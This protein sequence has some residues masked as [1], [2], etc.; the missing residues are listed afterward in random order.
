[1]RPDLPTGTVTFLFTDV[2]GSTGF[3]TSWERRL[4]GCA[5]R[6]PRDRARGLRRAGRSRGGH[7]GRRLLRRLSHRTWRTRGGRA[8]R[9]RRLA[10]RPIRVRM[11]LHTGTP[12]LSD[13]GYVG[14]DVHRAA[15]VAAL[16]HGGQIVASPATVALLDGE[17]IRDLGLHR[18]KDFDA[19][20][21]STRLASATSRPCE[22]RQRR[23]SDPDD[24]LPRPG[25]RALRGRLAR[26]RARPASALRS[27]APA[28]PARRGSR[29]S[30]AASSLR[31]RKAERCSFRSRRCGDPEFVLTTIAERLGAGSAG[32]DAVAARVGDRRTAPRWSTTSSTFSQAPPVH[33][34]SS[35]QPFPA[36]AR[37]HEPRGAARPGRG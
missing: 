8:D 2:E 9:E 33:S 20:L 25:A 3:C 34:P 18:L 14:V 11:G 31:T 4:R 23:P 17:A 10:G 6:A 22:R 7:A 29:S 26:V 5:R 24:A 35:R 16:A 13:E 37:R 27:S 12:V 36:S 30:S 28:E 1:M 15:R 32:V 19:G 21:V